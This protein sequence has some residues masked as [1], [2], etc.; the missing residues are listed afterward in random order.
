MNQKRRCT[1]FC[2]PLANWAHD[3]LQASMDSYV[4]SHD[5][6]FRQHQ[7][8]QEK[9]VEYVLSWPQVQQL[10]LNVCSKSLPTLMVPEELLTGFLNVDYARAALIHGPFERKVRMSSGDSLV[11]VDFTASALSMRGVALT[12]DVTVMKEAVGLAEER[13]YTSPF[14]LSTGELRYFMKGM[15][16]LSLYLHCDFSAAFSAGAGSGGAIPSV[17]VHNDRGERCRVMNLSEF[18][19]TSAKYKPKVKRNGITSTNDINHFSAFIFFREFTPVSVLT[20]SATFPKDIEDCIRRYCILSG[21]WC[22]IW[23]TPE[24]FREAGHDVHEGSLGLWVFDELGLPLFLVNALSC[25]DVA[26]AFSYVYPNDIIRV[27]N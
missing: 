10:R 9:H 18:V 12:D 6:P 5:E 2:K 19:T 13:H 1:I 7:Q 27:V 8:H 24:E 4:S 25:L 16:T 21:C 23:G 17:L 15:N 22:T 11:T 20:R 3:L 26:A 14:W